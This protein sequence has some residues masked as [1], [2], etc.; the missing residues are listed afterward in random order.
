MKRITHYEKNDYWTDK[1]FANVYL[2]DGRKKIQ[3]IGE[4]FKAPIS[5]YQ[6]EGWGFVRF[7]GP[8]LVLDLND[9]CEW[10][11]CWAI[12][13]A[14]EEYP[15]REKRIVLKPD[16]YIAYRYVENVLQSCDD[17][18]IEIYFDDIHPDM[19]LGGYVIHNL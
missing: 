18:R 6:Y 12:R 8:C 19:T 9:V 16:P 2:S 14:M 5:G 11:Q 13:K 17:G 1:I 4:T 7:L 15:L 3:I 10:D